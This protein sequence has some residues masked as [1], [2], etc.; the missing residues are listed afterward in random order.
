MTRE[1]GLFKYTMI[2]FVMIIHKTN[3]KE[4]ITSKRKKNNNTSIV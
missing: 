4:I 3:K 2:S 1:R